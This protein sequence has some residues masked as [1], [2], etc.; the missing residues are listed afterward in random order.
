[1]PA[2]A[3]VRAAAL[4]AGQAPTTMA[5]NF[6]SSILAGA[7]EALDGLG[8]QVVETDGEDAE[9]DGAGDGGPHGD[10]RPCWEGW[11]LG[12]G[13]LALHEHHDHHPQVVEDGDQAGDD[14]DDGQLGVAG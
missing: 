9:T 4:P 10:V 8:G 13:H 1:M 7:E 3:M 14:A 5:S 12:D 6:S 2:L 11:L